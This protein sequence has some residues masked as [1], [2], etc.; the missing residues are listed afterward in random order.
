MED[1]GASGDGGVDGGG[2][3]QVGVEEGEAEVGGGEGEEVGGGRAWLA[4]AA[5]GV[6]LLEEG[7]D[8]PR[9]YEPVGSRHA[10]RLGH[11]LVFLTSF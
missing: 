10:N 11:F 1:A 3:E 9:A 4:R 2:V 7:S 6:A 5:D 8:Q